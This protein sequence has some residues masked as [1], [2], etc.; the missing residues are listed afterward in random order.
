MYIDVIRLVG[1]AKEWGDCYCASAVR[2]GARIARRRYLCIPT[3]VT[4]NGTSAAAFPSGSPLLLTP[5]ALSP[6]LACVRLASAAAAAASDGG[7]FHESLALVYKESSC[8]KTPRV[9][10]GFIHYANTA[11]ESLSP[12]ESFYRYRLLPRFLRDFAV[13]NCFIP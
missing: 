6:S 8:Q 12:G 3:A 5:F 4:R 10:P 13:I 7:N 11:L 2:V 9:I 1:D